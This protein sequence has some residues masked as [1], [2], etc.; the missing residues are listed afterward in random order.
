MPRVKKTKAFQQKAKA[1]Q[2]GNA[3]NSSYGGRNGLDT[4]FLPFDGASSPKRGHRGK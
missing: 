2:R 4:S 1:A 3:S